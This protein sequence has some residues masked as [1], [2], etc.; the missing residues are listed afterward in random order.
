[1][2]GYALDD[3]AKTIQPMAHAG[4]ECGYLSEIRLSWSEDDPTGNGPAG[5][6]I[7]SGEAVL[8]EDIESGDAGFFWVESA[9]S[10]GFRAVICLPLANENDTFGMLAL[11]ATESHPLGPDERKLLQELA[12][13]LAFGIENIRGRRERQRTQEVVLK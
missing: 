7:R 13:D 8:T 3:A 12:D 2:V 6:A 10:R 1:W 4:E 9:L 11:Y 5:R